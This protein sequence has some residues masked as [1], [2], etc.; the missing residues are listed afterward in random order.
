MPTSKEDGSK[1]GGAGGAGLLEFLMRAAWMGVEAG[2][3]AEGPV[4]PGVDGSPCLLQV[5]DAAAPAGF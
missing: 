4:L 5:A 3:E 1:P 2:L